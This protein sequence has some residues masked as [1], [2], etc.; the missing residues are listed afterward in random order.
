MEALPSTMSFS[1]PAKRTSPHLRRL[2][3][4]I[5]FILPLITLAQQARW[6][7]DQAKKWYEQQPWPVGA[8]YIPADAINE[9]EMWQAS[10]FNPA[11][12]D[13]EFGWAQ[14]LGMNT[15]RVF[16][17][18]LVWEQDAAGYR[19]RIEQFL[20]IA[21]RHHIRPVFVLLDSCWDPYPKLGPQR[22]AIPGVHN[23]GWVQAPGSEMLRD[24]EQ[25][26]RLKSYVQG[27]VGAFAND[28]RI[29]AWDVWNEPE[30]D[31]AASYGKIELKNK[32]ELVTALLPQVFEWIREV[33]PSQPLTSGIWHNFA[34]LE[35]MRPLTKIQLNQS[36]VI[37]FHL[38]TWPEQ[39][40]SRIQE[41]KKYNRPLLCTEYM[42]RGVG[43]TFDSVL[44][45]AKRYKVGAIN[46]GLVAGKT[47]T[48][49][50][51]DSWER[52]YVLEKPP[53]W[54]H[55]VFYA[56]GTL[57]REREGAILRELTGTR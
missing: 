30:N 10:T 1:R 19:Q 21:Q 25:Y 4:L 34:S 42:A 54:F 32:E 56:D 22:P 18:N 27:V 3:A 46:W 15:M 16:L 55:D 52:P 13:R 17:H 24:P 6:T 12:I 2:L 48:Y 23:S 57:Y 11:E 39:F 7:E 35:D 49:L 45:I 26:P 8:N 14:D 33:H 50:P 51:W 36:D 38:Y 43:S 37:S 5:I 41:L 44:P 28:S 31:N 40:E 47:Q 53:V 29:L 20:A 9:L